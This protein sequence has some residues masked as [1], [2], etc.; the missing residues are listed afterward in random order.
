MGDSSRAAAGVQVLVGHSDHV[1][2]GWLAVKERAG[3]VTHADVALHYF[4]RTERVE[5]ASLASAR[6]T[7]RC[8]TRMG[9]ST[10]GPRL[11]RPVRPRPGTTVLMEP[12][13]H[14]LSVASSATAQSASAAFLS[15]RDGVGLARVLRHTRCSISGWSEMTFREALQKHPQRE[16]REFLRVRLSKAPFVEDLHRDQEEGTRSMIEG[17]VGGVRCHGAVFAY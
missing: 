3:R 16:Q 14:E 6:Q 17:A 10:S 7:A 2:N 13:L 15:R 8:S 12:I 11:L 4:R 5:Q 1:L 9:A